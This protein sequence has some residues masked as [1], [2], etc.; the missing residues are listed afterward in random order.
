MPFLI[1]AVVLVAALSL[2][3]L[4]F[5]LGVIRRLREHTALLAKVD[6]RNDTGLDQIM[7]APGES[8]AEFET[9]TTDGEPVSRADLTGATL[10]GFFSASCSACTARLP[11]FVAYAERYPGGRA[12]VLGVVVGP[13]SDKTTQ[14]ATTLAPVARVVRDVDNGAMSQAFGVIG[15][16]AMAVLD[17]DVVR[18]S[19]YLMKSL[20]TPATR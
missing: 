8:V 13:D 7:L 20:P 19:G 12:Q 11:E 1:T 10:I 5:T 4:V 6:G 2:L 18:A 17:D 16:P 15:L 9:R 3:N 14:I